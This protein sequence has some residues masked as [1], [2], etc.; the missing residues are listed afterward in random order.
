[1]GWSQDPQPLEHAYELAQR[2]I[3]LDESLPLGH[4]ILGEVYLHKKQYEKAIAEQ[5][6]TI[7]LSPND[8]DGI[9][10]LG[11]I[12]TWAGRPEETI[13]LVKKAMRLNPMYP[14]EYLWNLGHAYYLMGRHEDA[15]ETL[16]RARDRNPDYV[17]V[18]AYLTA[19]Y[20]ELGREEEARAEAA[21]VVR[22]SPQI[23]IKDWRPRLPI[24]IKRYWI[25]L[26]K[27]SERQE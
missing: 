6:K 22:L 13:G 2:A 11:G 1:M 5:E 15:V 3:T 27:L 20:G 25:A 26:L 14:T 12:L 8:A 23:S 17:P 4:A 24:K 19:S 9:A 7:A 18:H 16:K 10:G 21:E